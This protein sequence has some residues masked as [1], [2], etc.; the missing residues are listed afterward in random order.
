[1]HTAR[2]SA[3]LT[4]DNAGRLATF[5]GGNFWAMLERGE[6][7]PLLQPVPA[8]ALAVG[9]SPRELCWQWILTYAP[10]AWDSMHDSDQAE[11]GRQFTT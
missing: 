11:P 8:I 6:R 9:L 3:G 5:A 4:A 10:S 7:K 1:M 2:L